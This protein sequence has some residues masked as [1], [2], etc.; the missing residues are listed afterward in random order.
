MAVCLPDPPLRPFRSG[1]VASIVRHADD[2][3]VWRNL[4]DRFP[5][6]YTPGDA[7]SWIAFATSHDPPLHFAI[8]LAG[9]A[10][11]GIGIIPGTD[12]DRVSAEVGYWLGRAAWGRGLATGA[13]AS[14]SAYAF[15]TFDFTRLFATPFDFNPASIRVLEKAGW[16]REGVLRRAVIK[17][18]RVADLLVYALLRP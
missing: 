15:R 8:E 14:L 5:H 3:D 10:V 16:T 9:E 2:R 4:R 6:P 12:V 18:G 7:E 17:E 13:L 11:G 1:D